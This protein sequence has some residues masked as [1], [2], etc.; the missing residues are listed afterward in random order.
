MEQKFENSR[1]PVSLASKA[2]NSA[3]QNY[4]ARGLELLWI[5]E[6]LKAWRYYLRGKKFVVYTDYPT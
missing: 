3:Q 5:V 1:Q 2:S 6:L 4:V